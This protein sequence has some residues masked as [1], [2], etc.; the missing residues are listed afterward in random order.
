MNYDNLEEWQIVRRILENNPAKISPKQIAALLGR[1]LQTVYKWGENPEFSGSPI[2]KDMMLSFSN[3]TNDLR[4][5]GWYLFQLGYYPKRLESGSE[6]NGEIMDDIMRL[7]IL[8]GELSRRLLD[9]LADKKLTK[10]ECRDLSD[11]SEM[12]I[13]ELRNFQEELKNIIDS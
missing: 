6:C 1:G 9:S 7:D 10:Q 2:P 8:R 5:F 12:M 11:T 4:L 13:V 3:I